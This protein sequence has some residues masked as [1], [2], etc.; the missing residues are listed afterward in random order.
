MPAPKVFYCRGE[1]HLDHVRG[2]DGEVVSP[3]LYICWYDPASGRM[4]RRSTGTADLCIAIEVLD[5]HYLAFHQP[6][7]DDKASYTVHQAMIDCWILHGS[8][9]SSA[10][11]IRAR[12]KLVRRFIGHEI[13]TGVLRE[14]VLP[15]VLDPNG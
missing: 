15:K 1:F 5:R 4:Q 7:D 8:K 9:Q 10:D 12:L 2:K 6:A 14:P 11:A 3:N 13:E